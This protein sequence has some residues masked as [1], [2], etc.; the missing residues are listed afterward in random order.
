MRINM[1]KFNS[2]MAEAELSQAGLAR[3][4]G[5]TDARLSYQMRKARAKE[6]LKPRVVGALALAFSRRIKRPV[7]LEDFIMASDLP[8]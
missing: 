6:H 4:L 1:L 5:C 2:L 8:R 7:L 3:A